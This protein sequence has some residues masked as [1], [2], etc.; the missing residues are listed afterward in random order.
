MSEQY[1]VRGTKDGK[2]A[3]YDVDHSSGYPYVSSWMGK[4]TDDVITALGWIKDC[5][6]KGYAAMDNPRVCRIVY[7]EVDVAADMKM[8]EQMDA[9]LSTLTPTQKALLKK[10]L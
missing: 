4:R 3:F 8:L 5:G 7:E 1:V 6:P 10:K 2:P 9:L